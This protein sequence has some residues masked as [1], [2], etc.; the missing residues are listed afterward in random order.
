MQHQLT[1]SLLIGIV[2]SV[3]AIVTFS[4]AAF[5][6]PRDFVLKNNSRSTV[7][8][9]YVSP[10]N[11]NSWGSDVLGWSW[12]Y[13]GYQIP[14]TF[15]YW[16]WGSTCYFDIKFVTTDFEPSYMWDVDLCST[17]TINFR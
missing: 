10:T 14:I 16:G 8:S 17:S 5:A 13:S 1:K 11:T 4:Q 12:L 2:A 15:N 3:L 6:D 9:V 7:L